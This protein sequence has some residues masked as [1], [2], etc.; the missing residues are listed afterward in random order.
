MALSLAAAALITGLISA[1]VAATNA[2]VNVAANKKA[3]Q[4]N[5]DLTNATN[6]AAL[7]QVR[8]VNAF[9]AAEAQ[10]QRDWETEMSNT[11]IQRSMADYSAA[12]LNPILSVP[13]GAAVPSGATASG[14]AAALK[15]PSVQA[16]TIDLSGVSSAIQ[17]MTN[18]MLTK[19]FL[20]AANNRND[21]SALYNSGRLANM[22][23]QVSSTERLNNARIRVM[24]HSFRKN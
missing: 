3:N 7:Q 15:S 1:G 21:L 2:G 18:F 13:G 12:G 10:K 17:S 8:E 4:T 11:A 6:E 5:I 19:G 24:S 22:T 9:N 20:D 14:N 16:E 23:R